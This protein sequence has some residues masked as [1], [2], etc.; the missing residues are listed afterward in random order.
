MENHERD[1]L[2]RPLAV[3]VQRVS[4]QVPVSLNRP[5]VQLTPD[6]GLWVAIRNRTEAI[7]FD[8]Y[9]VFIDE[10]LCKGN[11]QFRRGGS[12][13]VI[14]GAIGSPTLD[15]RSLEL[16]QRPAIYGGDAYNLLKFATEVF[17]LVQAGVVKKNPAGEHTLIDPSSFKSADERPR[18][19]GLEVDL[20]TITALLTDYFGQSPNLPYLDRVLQHL[21]V[22][23]E[24]LP[25]CGE[26]LHARVSSPSMLELI[27]SYW[28][29]EGMLVQTMKALAM[30]FENRRSPAEKDPL[31]NLELD[32]LRPLNN[33][34]WGYIQDE[35][36]Q[37]TVLRRAYEYD[38]H[39]GLSLVG[40]A[41]PT[42]NG[43][44][45]RSKFIEAFHNLLHRTAKFFKEDSDTTVIADGFP[46]LN[47]LREVH[48]LLA[49]G[50]HNQFGELPWAA[51]VQMLSEQW[52]LARPEMQEFLRGR[53][54]VPYHE[55][56]MGAVDAMKRMQGWTDTS[57]S[58]FYNLAV[59]G[60]RILLSVRYGDWIAIDNT[61][62]QAKNWARYWRPEL[63]GYIHSYNTATG[64]DLSVDVTSTQDAAVRYAQP[65]LLLS[66]RLA[67]AGARPALAAPAINDA[68]QLP[69]NGASAPAQ[70]P[71][72]A[73]REARRQ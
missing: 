28:H 55:E 37:I 6:Q 13:D 62:E 63:Q 42:V 69:V 47:A 22:M 49:E 57:V 8:R 19:G 70:L 59:H 2:P 58:H 11:P 40:K 34:L 50:A 36:R 54:M 23:K 10:V 71:A 52:L 14:P 35:Y 56:W 1:R 51:R 20:D 66:R 41:V 65:S 5:D 48:L 46:L 30:R 60:E 21:P 24:S 26:L 4:T 31:A 68:P 61:H 15:Q 18:F 9:K 32:P 12:Q 39:Y 67:H 72:R 45:S 38:H 53:Y 7:S 3:D 16:K 43:A 25:F 33:L 29:E 44:D 27:W 64:V 73:R 17:L